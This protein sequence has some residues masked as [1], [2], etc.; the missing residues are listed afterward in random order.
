MRYPNPSPGER[1]G[2]QVVIEILPP[3]YVPAGRKGAGKKNSTEAKV[4]CDCGNVR[5][6]FVKNIMKKKAPTLSCAKCA[7]K[8]RK[9][10]KPPSPLP[11][12]QPN[13]FIREITKLRSV[14]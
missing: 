14:K 5:S 13:E 6:V 7:Q 11:T 1:F 10:P 2:Q 12:V 4:R 9:K 3:S 8:R